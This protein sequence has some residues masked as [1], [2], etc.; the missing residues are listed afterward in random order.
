[1]L[2]NIF[3]LSG[4]ANPSKCSIIFLDSGYFAKRVSRE[5]SSGKKNAEGGSKRP[6]R[7][8]KNELGVIRIKFPQTICIEKYDD[9]KQLG[10]LVLRQNGVTVASSNNFSFFVTK[11][12]PVKPLTGI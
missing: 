4:L 3:N 5:I 11:F 6:R 7:I 2:C 10:R 1:M 12:S 8:A 9:N